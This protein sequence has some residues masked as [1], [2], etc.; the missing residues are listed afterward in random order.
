VHFDEAD[1]LYTQ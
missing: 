1:V